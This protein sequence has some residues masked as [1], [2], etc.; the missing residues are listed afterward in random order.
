MSRRK[1]SAVDVKEKRHRAYE[2]SIAGRYDGIFAL[3]DDQRPGDGDVSILR[4]RLPPQFEMSGGL[5]M[6]VDD[7]GSGPST[8]GRGQTR[9]EQPYFQG[10]PFEKNSRLYV[11]SHSYYVHDGTSYSGPSHA[12]RASADET[13][14]NSFAARTQLRN[15][16]L[17]A[18][19]ATQSVN[20]QVLDITST[21]QEVTGFPS[22][23]LQVSQPMDVLQFFVRY[24]PPGSS[25][26][27]RKLLYAKTNVTAGLYYVTHREAL[28]PLAPGVY[29]A[30]TTLP[31]VAVVSHSAVPTL[32]FEATGDSAYGVSSLQ[33]DNF[34]GTVSMN[35]LLQHRLGLPV[36]DGFVH[37]TEGRA[38]GV[39][40]L[41]DVQRISLY[42]EPSVQFHVSS[43][44]GQMGDIIAD[45]TLTVISFTI[46]GDDLADT[47]LYSI[48]GDFDVNSAR[49][50]SNKSSQIQ[51]KMFKDV[52][53][54]LTKQYVSKPVLVSN[55]QFVEVK[56]VVTQE[57][58]D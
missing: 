45:N 47:A 14:L 36:S 7:L 50:T 33:V 57:A 44:L 10:N 41:N 56:M 1:S 3:S 31:L 6:T 43:H 24:G 25:T 40:K 27:T 39:T 42:L 9:L 34:F 15:L 53:N 52:Y 4:V 38:R 5:E 12:G 32:A 28:F 46:S 35:S 20:D 21:S 13:V 49:M 30:D 51:F 58:E 55:H 29:Q 22:F 23:V 16:V 19:I 54:S 17:D 2:L 11:N 48:S 26:L 37:F 18:F 8:G